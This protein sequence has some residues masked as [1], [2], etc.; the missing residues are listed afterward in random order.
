ME[1]VSVSTVGGVAGLLGLA[2]TIIL[3]LLGWMR[4]HHKRTADDRVDTRHY[5]QQRVATL[6]ADAKNDRI[7]KHK[8]NERAHSAELRNVDLKSQL[9]DVKSDFARFRDRCNCHK[10]TDA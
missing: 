6:E 7:D 5:L 1:D 9:D 4:N 10:Q 2:T 3:A 8:A